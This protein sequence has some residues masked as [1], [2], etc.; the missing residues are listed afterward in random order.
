MGRLAMVALTIVLHRELPIAVLDEVD[1]GRDLGVAQIMRGKARLDRRRELADVVGR[2]LGK[3]DEQEA[4]DGTR[5]TGF[6]PW[7]DLSKSAP[8]CLALMRVPSRLYV[9]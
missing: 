6:S 1:L 4:G 9:H 3:A 5:C 7:Q 2:L 8:I